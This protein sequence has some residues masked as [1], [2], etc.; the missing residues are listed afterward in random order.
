MRCVLDQMGAQV[1]TKDLAGRYTFANVQAC[2]RLGRPLADIVGHDESEFVDTALQ[3]A[4]RASDRRVLELG[5]T[6]AGEERHVVTPPGETRRY[7]TVK[8]PLRNAAGDIVGLSVVS[9]DVTARTAASPAEAVEHKFR[10]LIAQSL[11]GVY[12]LEGDSFRYVNPFF[13]RMFGYDHADEVIGRVSMAALVAPEDR[14]GVADVVRRSIAGEPGLT[15]HRFAGLR[16]D[17][18]TFDV[19]VFG[20]AVVFEGRPALIGVAID[21]SERRKAEEE[22]EQQR[23]RQED[24]VQ[25]RTCELAAA[26]DQAESA[27]RA[28]SAFLANMS[29]ELRTPLNHISGFA[30]LLERDIADPGSRAKLARIG[31]AAENLLQLINSLLDRARI[32]S[33]QLKI[34]VVDFDLNLVLDQVERSTRPSAEHKGLLLTVDEAPGLPARLRGDSA[35]LA[36]ILGY[37]IDN[38]IKFSE[39]GCITVRIRQEPVRN[40]GVRLR[41]EVEDEGIGMAPDVSDGLFQLFNQGDNSRIRRFGGMGLG[42]DLSKRL[43]GL[44]GGEIGVTSELGRGSTFWFAL[45]FAVAP[46]PAAAPVGAVDWDRVHAA[47]ADMRQL[48]SQSDVLAKTRWDAHP[49]WFA[50]VLG[51]RTVAFGECMDNFDFD[52]ALKIL[53]EVSA[54][55]ASPA[56]PLPG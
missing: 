20:N 27:S 40:N 44:M 43:V 50:P 11:V 10:G 3:D 9:T 30:H 16:R 31:E 36:Q 17:G 23:R 41:F 29:H 47:V 52:I 24:L 7:W 18:S 6:I 55:P 19:E 42:L 13:A 56:A 2:Q 15:S 1:F 39:Q 53:R 22:L 45:P 48:L 32:E 46:V 37:L 21:I 14:D 38:A 51:E 12:H 34:D 28:K 4:T 8:S 25:A 49:E 5:E 26:L 33:D 54:A 35:R